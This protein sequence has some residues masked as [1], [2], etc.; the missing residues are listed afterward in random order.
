VGVE[1][2]WVHRY[3][4]SKTSRERVARPGRRM[5]RAL[6]AWGYTGAPRS[7]SQGMSGQAREEDAA[8]VHGYTGA[9]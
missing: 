9:L 7:N 2:V 5:Q 3:T 8:S 4:T 1:C 6:S